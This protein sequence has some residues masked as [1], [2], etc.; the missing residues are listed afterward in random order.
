[1]L[2]VWAPQTWGSWL[3]WAVPGACY[4]IDSRIE[5]FPAELLQDASQLSRGIGDWM[6]IPE[7]YLAHFYV[8]SAEEAT[9]LGSLL[10]PPRWNRVYA[11]SD[12]SIWQHSISDP[13]GIPDRAPAT[14][15]TAQAV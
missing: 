13:D 3:E 9:R 10:G 14:C 1:M 11:D 15:A 8:F 2:T 7:K 12:G 5:L 6:S 4:A